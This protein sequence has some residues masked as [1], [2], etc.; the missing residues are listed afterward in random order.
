MEVE[1]LKK[2]GEVIFIEAGADVANAFTKIL[3]APLGAVAE[4]AE[5]E[6]V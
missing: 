2:D 6:G 3:Q 1:I 5:G 4:A